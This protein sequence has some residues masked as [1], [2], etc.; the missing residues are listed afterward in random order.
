MKIVVIGANGTIG[1]AVVAVLEKKYE[2]IKVGKSSGDVTM[3]I[4]DTV[5]IKSAFESIGSVDAVISAAG[6]V[7]FNLFSDM[8]EEEWQVGLGSKLRGQINLTRE[9]LPYLNPNGSITL[10]SGILADE[11]IA[12]GTSAT[13]VNAGVEHFAMAVSTEL[14]KGIRINVVS[15]S[16]LEESLPVYGDFFPGFN[17][18]PASKVAQAYLRCVAGVVTGR[19]FKV[20]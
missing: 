8:T 3:D 16:V 17:A 7:A 9:V 19:V 13:T 20:L 10:T 2:V 4:T 6:D 5:S 1:S 12:M 14:P 18:V 11:P 15:P